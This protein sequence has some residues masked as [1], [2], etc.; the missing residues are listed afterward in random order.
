MCVYAC[1]RHARVCRPKHFVKCFHIKTKLQVV[2]VEY[3]F[4]YV[5]V[6]ICHGQRKGTAAEITSID[7]DSLVPIR[8]RALI[9]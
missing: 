9:T 4:Q 6:Q 8:I 2:I 7:G 3:D 1:G 5:I